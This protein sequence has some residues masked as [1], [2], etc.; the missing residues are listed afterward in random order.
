MDSHNILK[1]VWAILIILNVSGVCATTTTAYEILLGTSNSGSF[2]HFTGRLV[3]RIINQ[4]TVNIKCKAVPASGDI[5]N[6]TNLVQGAIDMALIDS[7]MLN[8]AK[9]KAGNFRFLDVDYQS[10]S[11]ITPM[12]NVPFILVVGENTSIQGLNDLNGKRINSGT[13]LS[14]QNLTFE[15]ILSAK[16]WSKKNFSLVAEISDSQSQDTMA[17]CHGGV[18]AMLYI[19]IHPDASLNQLFKRCKAKMADMNDE[20]IKSLIQNN[21]TFSKFIVPAMTYPSQTNDVMTFGTQTLLVT[22]HN[23]DTETV[24]NIL[25]VLFK[26]DK[27]LLNAHPALSLKKVSSQQENYTNMKLHQGAAKFFSER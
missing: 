15:T 13:P 22:S 17:F 2:S 3:E 18:D 5:H 19:G 1:S 12:Y 8:D 6:L 11:V 25:D 16:D 27:K 4:Q 24:Y 9:N 7:R 26:N 10:L 14:I 20:D 21:P 23:L